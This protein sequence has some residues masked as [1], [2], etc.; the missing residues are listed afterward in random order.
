[1][2]DVEWQGDRYLRYF[3]QGTIVDYGFIMLWD[4]TA[5]FC[6]NPSS[7]KG[8]EVGELLKNVQE[9]GK[10]RISVIHVFGERCCL[11]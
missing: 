8:A 6:T 3:A 5:L 1:M 7:L 4:I 10:L 2:E 9:G 11:S